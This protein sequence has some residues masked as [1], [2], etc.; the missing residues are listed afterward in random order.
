MEGITETPVD[1]PFD[2]GRSSLGTKGLHHQRHIELI[3]IDGM[4]TTYIFEVFAVFLAN[5]L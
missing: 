4:V 1:D 5:V 3:G 2:P